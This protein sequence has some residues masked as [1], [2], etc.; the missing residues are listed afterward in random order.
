MVVIQR[1]FLELITVLLSLAPVLSTPAIAGQQTDKAG[2]YAK[3]SATVRQYKET[4]ALAEKVQRGE[5]PPVAQRLPD[6]PL[7][8][9]PGDA[10]GFRKIGKYGGVLRKDAIDPMNAHGPYYD[11]SAIFV[12]K[13]GVAIPNAWKS[14]EATDGNRTW[15]FY[16]RRGMKW[17][18]G[19]P[20]T[21]DDFFFWYE[22]VAHNRDLTPTPP[23]LNP[24]GGDPPVVE[25]VDDYTIRFTFDK[26]RARFHLF[27][28]NPRTV[29]QTPKH[30]LT[31]FHPEYT[32]KEKLDQAMEQAGVSSWAQLFELK[33]DVYSNFNPE[34]PKINPWL[35]TQGM[36]QNP[37]VWG[38]RNPYYWAVDAEGNQLPYMDKKRAFVAGREG[39]LKLMQLSGANTYTW[40]ISVDAIEL[41][42]R[43]E[44]GGKL[45]IQIYPWPDDLTS[46]CL[47]FNFFSPDPFKRKLTRDQRFRIAMSVGINREVLSEVIYS[48]LVDPQQIGVSDPESP[49]YNRKLA[50]AYLDYDPA[51][52]NEL[53]D[54]MGLTRKDKAGFRLNAEGKPIQ[55]NFLTVTHPQWVPAYN[56]VI[57]QIAELGLKGNLRTVGWAQQL[58][59]LEQMEWD[60]YGWQDGGFGNR[61]PDQMDALVASSRWC[62]PWHQ[63]L[64]TDGR[65]GEQPP[66]VI[67]QTWQ[68]R[69]KAYAAES[70]RA[71]AS[72]LLEIQDIAAEHLWAVG[73]TGFPPGVR[74][75]DPRLRNL[76]ALT[77]FP[78]AMLWIDD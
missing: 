7:I 74:V 39:R 26:P 61:Y 10:Y 12:G 42:K 68:L 51:K 5:L 56:I 52:A 34:A 18:D 37:V 59:T 29:T 38:R 31:Q 14:W 65:V 43:A 67:M 35:L 78:E 2:E 76:G 60:C 41:F 53:L 57:E 11:Q 50:T 8:F 62:R 77:I 23:R 46:L 69:Q 3:H 63:W 75:H 30:Y 16:M 13:D 47:Y 33:W 1:T 70:D 45:K 27:F 44:E 15:T 64:V 66:A 20:Y 55:L 72:C 22:D 17:S 36:D 71:L 24:A 40:N 9:R 48:G 49:W 54:E 6:E 19:H 21:A 28:T 58:A 4:P 25:K 32:S 73:L